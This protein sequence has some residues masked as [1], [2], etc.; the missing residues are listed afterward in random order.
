M[1][2]RQYFEAA[3][4]ESTLVGEG[5]P[6]GVM[7]QGTAGR[8]EKPEL[9]TIGTIRPGMGHLDPSAYWES[10]HTAM[11]PWTGKAVRMSIRAGWLA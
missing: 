11:R 8:S 1:E 2:E 7:A 10:S 5:Y 9:M 4:D 6:R 3:E